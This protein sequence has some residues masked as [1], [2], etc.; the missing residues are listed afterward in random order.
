MNEWNLIEC[1]YLSVG[2]TAYPVSVM[3]RDDFKGVALLIYVITLFLMYVRLLR[4]YQCSSRL[5]PMWIMI[6]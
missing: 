3:E 6:R 4:F 5:G 1:T 2:L